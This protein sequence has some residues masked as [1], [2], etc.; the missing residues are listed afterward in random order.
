MMFMLC[1]PSQT[2]GEAAMGV[3]VQNSRGLG[4]G[5]NA[6][7]GSKVAGGHGKKNG[8]IR[9]EGLAL[10]WRTVQK[11]VRPM[12]PVAA[13][14]GRRVSP[15]PSTRWLLHQGAAGGED[16]EALTQRP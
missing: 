7:T 15:G 11:M 10:Q 2:A 13:A 1:C 9:Q 6:A 8:L 4:Q 12:G 14:S 16:I 3:A 5:G